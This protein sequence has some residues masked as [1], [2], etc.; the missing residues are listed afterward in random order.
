MEFILIRNFIPKVLWSF[1][2]SYAQNWIIRQNLYM[3]CMN[4]SIQPKL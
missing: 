1:L 4:G 2:T 3:M